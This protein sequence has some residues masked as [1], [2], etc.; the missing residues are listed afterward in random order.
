[1]A[2]RQWHVAVTAAAAAAAIVMGALRGPVRA[3]QGREPAAPSIERRIDG[4]F[5]RWTRP[6]M[7]GCAVGVARFGQV[8]Y[9]RGYGLANLEYG[10][11]IK[12]DTI[13]ES[14]SV[15]KQ[16]TAAAVALLAI[17]G[18]LSRQDAVRKYVPELPEFGVPITIQ[19][20]L[21]HTSGLRSQWPMLTLAGRPPGLAVHTVPE[22]LELVSGY[23]ELNF[24]PGDEF[25]YNNTAFTLL[26]V[27]VQRVSGKS[28]DAFTQE[29]LF[30][31]LGMGRTAWR[32]DFSKVV[33][34]RA[35]AYRAAAGGEFRTNMSFTNVIGNGGLLTTVGDLLKWNANLDRPNVGGQAMVDELQRRGRLNDNSQIDYAQGL[36]VTEY[37][38]V[39]EVSHGG[40]TAGYQTFLGRWPDERL[41]V[42]ILCNTTGTSPEAYA[43]QVVDLLLDGRLAQRAA[44]KTIAVPAG[45]LDALAGTYRE[46]ATDAVMRVS[47][48][49]DGKTLRMGGQIVAPSAVGV[50]SNADGSRTFTASVP[51]TTPEAWPAA[52]S[53]PRVVERAPNAKPRTWQWQAPFSPSVGEL[54][55]YAGDY[56]C[57]EL[58]VTYTF[59]VD[60]PQLR[61][62]FRPAQR[63]ALVPAYLDA[64]EGD[65][66][67]YRF[68]R[69]AGGA[70]TGLQI[71]AGRVR[72]LGF[73][74]LRPPDSR[75][76]PTPENR[77]A[78]F[79]SP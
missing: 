60:G 34:D 56:S 75:H 52:G 25:L 55:A 54:Q 7:P 11:P 13:F 70:V 31:P 48:G 5:E 43:H 14:G 74:R 36:Y 63:V 40:S 69:D 66:N 29:R 53:S 73:V 20:L 41:S 47:P 32:E 12:P 71:Y 42:A 46:P 44:V 50:L 18:K 22:I 17:D 21:N 2:G 28:L 57:D 39:R 68:T 67:V 64:F 16:F 51:G 35:T 30:R 37:R 1:M 23:R 24:K 78:T 45:T 76:P 65:G 58:G 77:P 79:M 9:T 61:L 49:A 19:H 59:Y 3:E 72:H 8:L 10:V 26:G 33:R 62:R 38:G 4:I 27:V 6:G 15:A